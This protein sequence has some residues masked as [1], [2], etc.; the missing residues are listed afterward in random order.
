MESMSNRLIS[1]IIVSSGTKQLLKSCLD[2]VKA[3]TFPNIETTV[4]DNS[5]NEEFGRGF[6]VAYP[7]I[8][9]YAGKRSLSYC[10]ALN[11]GIEQSRGDFILCLNDDV[12]LGED[13]VK[14]AL[15]GFD[16]EDKIGMVSGKIL[17]SNGKTID[18]VELFL[19]LCRSVNERGYGAEDTGQFERKRYIFGVNGA[20]AFYRR[21]MLDEVKLNS[22]YF[23]SD[24]RFFYEDL[25]IAWRAQNLGWKGFYMPTAVAFH[26]RGA[27]TR[28]GKGMNKGLARRFLNDELHFDLVKNRYLAIIKNEYLWSFLLHLPF[29][30]LYD[31][32]AWGFIL[33][34]RRRLLKKILR[35]KIPITPAFKKRR[36]LMKRRVELK[37]RPARNH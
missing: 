7:D 20:A 6:S 18:S 36:L 17:R 26:I 23:D 10:G 4:I 34:F 9:L 19:S 35:E 21:A 32:F 15:A 30:L 29:V 12:T 24:F 3:Q 37:A 5:L 16:V 28:Q 33:F 1:I 2:S 25:D 11:K 14:E 27:T 31:I 13:F 22:E 8:K